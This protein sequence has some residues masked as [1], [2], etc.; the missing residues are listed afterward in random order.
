MI[1]KLRLTLYVKA[2]V[3]QK[4][5]S[6]KQTLNSRSCSQVITSVG[7]KYK[8]RKELLQINKRKAF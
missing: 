6:N 7:L 2:T 5:K 4:Q 3:H 8:K 1:N